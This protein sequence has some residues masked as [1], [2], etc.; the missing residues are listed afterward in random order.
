[1]KGII[2]RETNYKDNDKILT[3][4]T[5]KLGKISCIA[6]GSVHFYQNI[7]IKL[8]EFTGG[9]FGSRI[10]IAAESFR[11][12]LCKPVDSINIT[13]PYRRPLR[14]SEAV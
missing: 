10:Y 11:D 3:V 1:M 7:C 9:F 5:D 8:I 13:H 6:K 12:I 4:L 2:I 14:G